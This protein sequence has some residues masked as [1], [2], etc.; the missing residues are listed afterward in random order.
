MQLTYSDSRLVVPE[1]EGQ[2]WA[3]GGTSEG[4]PGPLWGRRVLCLDSSEGFLDEAAVVSDS[5]DPTDCSPPGFSVH[6]LSQTKVL[7]RDTTKRTLELMD[8]RV[9]FLTRMGRGEAVTWP[10]RRGQLEM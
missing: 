4:A 3:G 2:A 6:G 10:L 9:T 1:T 8:S 5:C 7:E